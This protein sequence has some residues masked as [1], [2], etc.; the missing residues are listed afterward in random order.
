MRLTHIDDDGTA[1]MVD[2]SGKARTRRTARAAGRITLK[3]DTVAAVRDSAIAKG[4]VLGTA[5]IAGITAAKRTADLIP[6]CHAI[7]IDSVQVRFEVRDSAVEI[8]ALAVC[9]D[10]TGIEMEVLTAVAVAA[11]TIYDMCKA[12]DKTMRIEDIHLVEKTKED[13]V[14]CS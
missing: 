7:A 9:T 1:R 3:P 4:D 12:I 2:V 10:R 8:E 14:P 5:R 6:L 13:L 11:L